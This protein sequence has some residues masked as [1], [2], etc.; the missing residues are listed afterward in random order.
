MRTAPSSHTS[1]TAPS[2]K[3][4]L[5]PRLPPRYQFSSKEY[6]TATELNYYGFR[7]YSSEMGRWLSR[8]PLGERGGLNLHGFVRNDPIRYVDPLG[9]VTYDLDPSTHEGVPWKW[10]DLS[11]RADEPDAETRVTFSVNCLCDA[12][13]GDSCRKVACTVSLHQSVWIDYKR[14]YRPSG[15]YRHEQMHVRNLLEAAKAIGAVLEGYEKRGC[16]AK[17]VCED[18]IWFIN[19]W[20]NNYVIPKYLDIEATHT[21]PN[22]PKAGTDYDPITPMPPASNTNPRLQ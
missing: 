11:D 16:R 14:Y 3:V 4:L 17:S 10:A 8:D 19:K 9:L 6:D 22:G 12:C 5:Q 13:N 15:A 1:N 21:N 2:A 18:E 7:F 20:Y